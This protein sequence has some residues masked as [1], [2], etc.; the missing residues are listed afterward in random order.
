MKETRA[1][2]GAPSTTLQGFARFSN[3]KTSE[4]V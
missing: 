4:T 3:E 2:K 1:K